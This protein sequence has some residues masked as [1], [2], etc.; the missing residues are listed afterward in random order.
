VRIV[1]QKQNRG[2]SAARNAGMDAATG[3]YLHFMDVDDA[4]NDEFYQRMAAAAQDT[5]ADMACCEIINEPKPHRTVRFDQPRVLASTDEKLRVTNVARWGYAVR[6]LFRTAFLR[7]IELRFEEG[8]L[9]EDMPF[10]LQAVYH[11]NRVVMVPGAVYTYILRP[12]SIMQIRTRE[13]RRRRHRDHRHAKTVRHNFARR[14]GFRIPGVPTRL[15][16][17]SL[18]YVKWFT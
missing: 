8:R 17:L 1:E 15:G 4:I 10:S 5:G 6:Y 11:A 12:G 7:A 2:L 13:H 14:H 18:F 16:P 3:E 9:I